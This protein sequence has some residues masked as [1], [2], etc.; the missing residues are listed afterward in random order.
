MMRC[1]EHPTMVKDGSGWGA[2]AGVSAAYLAADGFTGAPAI[3]MEDAAH[4]ALWADLGERWRILELYFK[5]EPI[6]RWA[7][8][9]TAAVRQLRAQHRVDPN[10][11]TTV[12]VETFGAAVQ[13]GS[14]MPRTTEQAQYSIAFP[15]A[16]ALHRGKIDGTDVA[17]ERLHD[18]DI[19]ELCRRIELVERPDFTARFPRERI[20]AVTIRLRDGQTLRSDDTAARGD[21]EQPLS[22]GEIAAKFGELT[23]SLDAARRDK[24]AAA[25]A[26]LPGAQATATDLMDAVLAEI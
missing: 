19:A 20:A 11:I 18:P 12:R 22:D 15:V 26:S 14:R 17:D 23:K 9:A 7:Q 8:P 16:V 3:T 2:F 24:I 10:M 21:P 13:L 5:P 4:D 25:V 1:I 6:C